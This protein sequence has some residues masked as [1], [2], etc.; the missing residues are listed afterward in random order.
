MAWPYCT[1]GSDRCELH[2]SACLGYRALVVD[3]ASQGSDTGLRLTHP[4]ILRHCMPVEIPHGHLHYS[5]VPPMWSSLVQQPYCP[6]PSRIKHDNSNITITITI[7]VFP[8]ARL[9]ITSTS[10][11]FI[12]PS[13][14]FGL[15]PLSTLPSPIRHPTRNHSPLLL[16]N[17][18]WTKPA[19]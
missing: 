4:C 16:R 7:S 10:L 1:S 17:Q 3:N 11:P 19:K 2:N 8:M 14:H 5:T 15:S 9:H 13:S 6:V 12:P 18:K